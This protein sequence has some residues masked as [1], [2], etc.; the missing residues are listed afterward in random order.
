[1]SV[2]CFLLSQTIAQ[3]HIKNETSHTQR[4]LEL[5]EL[6]ENYAYTKTDSAIFYNKLASKLF[7]EA[8]E[9]PRYIHSLASLTSLYYINGDF[10]E[11][12]YLAQ[13]AYHKA[14]EYLPCKSPEYAT[15][16]HNLGAIYF[17]KSDLYNAIKYSHYSIELLQGIDSISIWDTYRNL[18]VIY[19]QIGD[20]HLA[21]K[22]LNGYLHNRYINNY[23]HKESKVIYQLLAKN[24][25]HRGEYKKSIKAFKMLIA[26]SKISNNSKIIRESLYNL[27]EINLLMQELDSAKLYIGLALKQ[28]FK[29]NH[30]RNHLFLISAKCHLPNASAIAKS[31][32]NQSLRLTHQRQ[33]IQGKSLFFPKIYSTF[34][35]LYWNEQQFDSVFYY[36]QKSLNVVAETFN[37]LDYHT[38]P[39]L[40]QYQ[41]PNQSLP[42]LSEKAKRLYDYYTQYTCNPKDLQASLQTYDLAISLIDSLRI[43][44]KTD[45][46]KQFLVEESIPIYEQAIQVAKELY[47]TTGQ[48]A[49]LYKAF[50][51]I[52]KS[53]GFLLHQA[54]K[55][56]TALDKSGIPDSLREREHD[57]RIDI[58]F[59]ERKILEEHQKGEDADSSHIIEWQDHVFELRQTY[60]K[61]EKRLEIEFPQYYQMKYD[62]SVATIDEVRKELL[63]EDEWMLEYFWGDHTLYVCGISKSDI[64]FEAISIDSTWVSEFRFFIRNL[65]DEQ[66]IND[67]YEELYPELLLQGHFYYQTL[68]EKICGRKQIPKS[69]LIIPDGLLGYVPFDLLL[70]KVAEPNKFYNYK[71]CPYLV[72]D[73]RTRYG[74]SATVLRN[75]GRLKERRTKQRL[76]QFIGFAPEYDA[77]ILYTSTRDTFGLLKA[78]KPEVEQIVKTIGGDQLSGQEATKEAFLE[79]ASD[80]RIIHFAGHT[81]V[82]D[83]EPMLSKLVFSWANDTSKVPYGFVNAH[84]LYTLMLNADLAVLSACNAGNGKMIRG[85]GIMSLSR[86]FMYAGTPNIVAS[87]W[88]A[89]DESTKDFMTYFYQNLESGYGKDEALRRAK[90]EALE[91]IDPLIMHPLYWGTFVL[92]GDTKSVYFPWNWQ[93]Y[94]GIFLV[95]ALVILLIANRIRRSSMHLTT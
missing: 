91:K 56:A 23:R 8:A 29:H 71:V 21:S 5:Y 41:Y 4:A 20:Y 51:F 37:D 33:E 36:Y 7:F 43:S 49:Y 25:Q 24:L 17:D 40:D 28:N 88:P 54:L 64:R 75:Q 14:Q 55:N 35:D 81:H 74:Y 3:K 31:H 70:T 78:N 92:I 57:L 1:V 77:D 42:I 16:L 10:E 47:E 61:L 72:R 13:K 27:A 46:S 82:N 94:L 60:Q 38:N 34:A 12:E 6:A 2:T 19:S 32:L 85:E 58:A 59:Y 87:L 11:S 86:G 66:W 62:L 76:K 22:Y 80:Y 53:K 39:T 26:G 89:N 83:V 45:A 18:G 84:D 73:C 15:I 68:V 93:P 90:V 63:S 9:W 52:E 79:R 95:G 50:E 65:S 48:Y 30:L 69:L 67:N 44:F